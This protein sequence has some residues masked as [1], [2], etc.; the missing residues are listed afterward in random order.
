M[1]RTWCFHC[2]AWVQ[3]LVGELRSCKL[4]SVSK[5]EMRDTE[6]PLCPAAPHVLLGFKMREEELLGGAGSWVMEC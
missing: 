5:K 2:R 3:S 1:V 6:R 4:H